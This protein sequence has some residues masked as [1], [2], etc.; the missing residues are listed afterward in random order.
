MDGGLIR[1]SWTPYL[2]ILKSP[3]NTRELPDLQQV[4]EGDD[5]RVYISGCAVRKSN[6][7]L[8]NSVQISD[9]PGH[10]PQHLSLIWRNLN[11]EPYSQHAF[12]DSSCL[13]GRGHP[14]HPLRRA[15]C[16]RCSLC[17]H[18]N[19]PAHCRSH[20]HATLTP[21]R[22][23][24]TT[25]TGGGCAFARQGSLTRPSRPIVSAQTRASMSQG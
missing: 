7:C 11:S 16:R 2:S 14:R 19:L 6:H 18:S 20:Q 23:T 8:E 15:S 12:H 13:S 5:C 4:Q 24:W 10:N 25:I 3:D 21:M 9:L 1:P 22:W 17:M